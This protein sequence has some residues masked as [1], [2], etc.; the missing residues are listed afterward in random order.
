VAKICLSWW[1][2]NNLQGQETTEGV[3]IWE[4][5]KEIILRSLSLFDGI[6]NILLKEGNHAGYLV[7]R[8]KSF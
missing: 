6:Q 4:Q 1:I 2:K 5:W 8:R 7:E 3:I